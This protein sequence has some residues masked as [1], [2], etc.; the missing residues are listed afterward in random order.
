MNRLLS[1]ALAL[2][3]VLPAAGAC[4]SSSVPG[5]PTVMPPSGASC[6]AIA[7]RAAQRVQAIAAAQRGCSTDADCV[8]VG[9]GASCFDH[10]TTS[11]ARAGQPAVDAMVADVGAHEC[12]E[13]AA[14]GCRVEV[15]PCAPPPAAATCR[16]GQCQ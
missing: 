11:I 8:I 5:E 12:R 4:A 2:V 9:Q 13:F 14:Q 15:P 16:A 1:T 3:A 10:C 7:A 6:S